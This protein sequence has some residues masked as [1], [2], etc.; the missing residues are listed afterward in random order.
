[1]AAKASRGQDVCD[2]AQEITESPLICSRKQDLSEILSKPDLTRALAYSSSTVH[3]STTA[4]QEPLQAALSDN[5]ALATHLLELEAR[6]NA[7]RTAT[8]S[9]LL[10]THALERQWRAKQ[11]EMDRALSPFSPSSLYQKL[12]QGVQ[13]QE[14]I[15][16]ALEESF[17]DGDGGMASEREVTE[18]VRRYREGKKIYYSRAERKLRWDEGRV[19]GWR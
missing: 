16:S 14:M 17:L 10:S 12:G 11:L 8:Q 2:R 1:M 6:L 15:C 18:W 9:Q 13:E 5:I 3:S 4:S 7:A 19:G